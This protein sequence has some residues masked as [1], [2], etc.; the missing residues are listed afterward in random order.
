MTALRDLIDAE[1]AA[2]AFFRR[3]VR[4]RSPTLTNKPGRALE[5]SS[6]NAFRAGVSF[7]ENIMKMN[8]VSGSAL[9][10]AA[11]A[12][13]ASGLASAPAAAKSMQAAVHCMG[14]NTCKGTSACK[15]AS[16]ACKGQNSC[17]GQGWLPVKSAKACTKKGG[18]VASM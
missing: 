18:T 17:K 7:R 6:P 8:V 1:N 3:R 4:N 5:R 15:S 9:A 14:I 10:A 12:L 16:N 11:I 13:A 2:A